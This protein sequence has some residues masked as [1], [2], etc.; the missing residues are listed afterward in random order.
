MIAKVLISTAVVGL[1]FTAIGFNNKL[2]LTEYTLTSSKVQKPLNIVFLSDIHSM[3]FKDGGRNLFET[4]D[5][6]KPDCVLIGGDAFHKYGEQEDFERSYE[7]VKN[8]ALNFHNCCFVTGNHEIESGKSEEITEKMRFFGVN[9]LGNKSYVFSTDSGQ[10]YLVGGTDYSGVGVEEVLF[11]KE[12]FIKTA[13]ETGL[14]SVLVR[15]IPMQVETDKNIDLILSGHNHGGLWRFPKTKVGVAGGGGK[16]FPKF[17]HGKYIK[18]NSCLIVG[19][20]I[21]TETYYI[22]RIYN[23]PEVVLVSVVPK[24]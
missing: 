2:K 24:T 17:T 8:L 13:K 7:L 12:E 16:L 22:P 1:A 10:Q 11:Q 15:H 14:F 4:I 20:G 23:P 19:S 21:T 3:K 5:R 9:I 18:N 6:A